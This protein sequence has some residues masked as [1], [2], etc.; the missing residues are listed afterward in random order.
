[1]KIKSLMDEE[2][3]LT[4][5]YYN[6]IL[7]RKIVEEKNRLFLVSK[8]IQM[9]QRKITKYKTGNRISIRLKTS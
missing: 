6:I 1:M 8:K 5:F 7:F 2:R 9:S 3:R 4:A